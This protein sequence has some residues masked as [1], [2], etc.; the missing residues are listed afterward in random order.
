MN[1][2]DTSGYI[3]LDRT[4]ES[5]TVGLR[6]RKDLGDLGP[7]TE[8]I[9]RYG[10]LQ[11]ITIT[12]EGLLL[13]GARRLAAIRLLGWRTVRVW[14]RSG[15]SD[16]L[17][18]L[19]AEQDD[20]VLHKE[21]SNLEAAALYRELKTVLMEEAKTREAAGWFPAGNS[22]AVAG[23]SDSQPP[24]N[25][26]M[27]EAVGK[28]RVQAAKLITGKDS[29]QL[30]ERIN[31]LVDLSA[32]DAQTAEI[33]AAAQ[34][35]L[36]RIEHGESVNPEHQRMNALLVIAQLD[37]LTTNE[38]LGEEQRQAAADE[39]SKLRLLVPE[40]RSAELQ[41]MAAE[42]LQRV[43]AGKKRHTTTRT[44]QTTAPAIYSPRAFAVLWSDLEGWWK[45]YE[46]PA[47]AE[48]LSE[49]QY[50]MFLRVLDGTHT[51]AEALRAAR[52]ERSDG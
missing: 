38:T 42:A 32:D 21:L 44:P 28:S 7:L 41:R 14:V 48:A 46:V 35:A 11:P 13:C 40:E 47:V 2:E 33:R 45:H 22:G 19:I 31:R 1:A 3:E 17:G 25:M 24:A 4:V 26:R 51:F 8:S 20:N 30:L 6:H 43:R 34:T 23:G 12:P 49:A 52:A 10:L 50:A 36:E 16:Q 18:N 9:R 5:I 37:H 39:A 29:S 27:L 15:I